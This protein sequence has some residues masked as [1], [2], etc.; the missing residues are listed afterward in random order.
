MTV[1]RPGPGIESVRWVR[2][3]LL[4]LGLS[5]D[6]LVLSPSRL[7]SRL[8]EADLEA[9]NY[10]PEF[11]PLVQRLQRLLG[12]GRALS[13]FITGNR[14]EEQARAHAAL[15]IALGI[16]PSGRQVA[17]IDAD[18]LRPG[19]GGLVADSGAEG[20]IDLVRF[21]RSTRSLLLRPVPQGPWLLPAGSFPVD[22]PVPL[23]PDSLRSV[24]YRVSQVCD[25]ALYVGPLP[26]RSE[27]HPLARVCD[28]VV[29]VMQD[30][31]ADAA[32]GLLDSVDQ[33][34]QQNAHLAGVVLYTVPE[35]ARF[36]EPKP[37]PPAAL[38]PPPPVPEAPFALPPLFTPL[39]WLVGDGVAR[40]LCLTGRRIDAEESLRI[41]LV[42][43]VV[44]TDRLAVEAVEIARQVAE[45][46]QRTLETTKRY[47][48]GNQGFGFEDSFRIEHDDVFDNF[49]DGA[50]G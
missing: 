43:R 39:R 38:P 4:G 50:I 49:L 33:L 30:D 35:P 26:I 27:L 23:S 12:G 20:V 21:G 15:Q 10:L 22:D 24:V 25:L 11:G 8:G 19:L 31:S 42:S 13:I 3:R 48:T 9:A 28:H 44:P 34:Q 5:E 41:G 16:L 7:A 1:G 17:I 45:A 40:D 18:F 37:A 2:E 14:G 47:L 29:Y 46:P 32:A 6:H 36:A